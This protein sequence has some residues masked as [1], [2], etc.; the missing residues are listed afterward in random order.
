M[1]QCPVLETEGFM[2][3]ANLSD[4]QTRTRMPLDGINFVDIFTYD[5]AH[6]MSGW[7]NWNC[8]YILPF[9]N[10]KFH[11]KRSIYDM[12]SSV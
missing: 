4:N 5:Q 2:T 7:R 3:I 6:C 9:Y 10:K 11:I 12:T 1:T 8:A